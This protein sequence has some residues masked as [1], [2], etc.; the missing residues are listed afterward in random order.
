MSEF[1]DSRFGGVWWETAIAIAV[2]CIVFQLFPAMPRV[3][4]DLLDF[5][6]WSRSAWLTANLVVLFT[7]LVVRFGPSVYDAWRS[8]RSP[9]TDS[10][11]LKTQVTQLLQEDVRIVMRR[12]EEARLQSR[13]RLMF[14]AG[15]LPALVIA[16]AVAFAFLKNSQRALSSSTTLLH[17]NPGADLRRNVTGVVGVKFRIPADRNLVATHVGVFDSGGNGLQHDYRAGLFEASQEPSQHTRLLAETIIPYGHQADL[18]E[19]FRWIALADPIRL[20]P[21]TDYVL[22]VETFGGWYGRGAED[23]HLVADSWPAT[24]DDDYLQKS[25]LETGWNTAVIENDGAIADRLLITD[26]PWPACPDREELLEAE[27]YGPVNL[28]FAEPE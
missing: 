16:F 10:A 28:R 1:R 5:R 15:F 11:I 27:A 7:L 8:R 6:D 23:E 21:N 2:V 9:G 18:M 26:R 20:K 12:D 3:L 19:S 17:P 25:K 4:V 22:A 14:Y 24:F 13:R